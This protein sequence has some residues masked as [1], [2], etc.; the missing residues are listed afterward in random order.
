MLLHFFL[1][2]NELHFVQKDLLLNFFRKKDELSLPMKTNGV[3]WVDWW[4]KDG[5]HLLQ[6]TTNLYQLAMRIII[7]AIT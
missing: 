1:R 2:F 5:T 6:V 3:P 4:L 7:L